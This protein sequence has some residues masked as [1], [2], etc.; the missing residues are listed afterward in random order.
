[1]RRAILTVI[2]CGFVC[3]I[4]SPE[5][6]ARAPYL[7]EFKEK[8]G[9]DEA[10][11]KLIDETK[12]YICHIGSKDKKRRNDFGVALSKV[13]SKNEKDKEKISE[14]LG[15]VEK[16]KSPDGKTFG[17]RIKEHELPVKPQKDD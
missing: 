10:Y 15:K 1:M 6:S 13:I 17:E 14:A 11:G 16:E 3:M 8:Y 9:S 2:F 4:S 12:C 5:G 7:K